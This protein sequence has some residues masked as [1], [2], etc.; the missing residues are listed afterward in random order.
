MASHPSIKRGGEQALCTAEQSSS[1]TPPKLS[2]TAGPAGLP[3]VAPHRQSLT[4]SADSRSACEGDIYVV[5]AAN[6][7]RFHLAV[8]LQG[9]FHPLTCVT[10]ASIQ[11]TVRH[12]LLPPSSTATAEPQ[13]KLLFE[14]M[15]LDESTT[16]TLPNNAVVIVH[17]EAPV[18]DSPHPHCCSHALSQPAGDG[19]TVVEMLS[20]SLLHSQAVPLQ[21]FCQPGVRSAMQANPLSTG[22]PQSCSRSS[23]EAKFTANGVRAAG[24]T[25]NSSAMPAPTQRLPLRCAYGSEGGGSTSSAVKPSSRTPSTPAP[26]SL[27]PLSKCA[28][29]N[30]G[31]PRTLTLATASN[32]PSPGPHDDVMPNATAPPSPTKHLFPSPRER[33][34]NRACAVSKPVLAA[35]AEPFDAFESIGISAAMASS[36]SSIESMPALQ[37]VNGMRSPVDGASSVEP[38][39]PIHKGSVAS[40][41]SPFRSSQR[42]TAA[43][44]AVAS[45]LHFS[46]TSSTV[47]SLRDRRRLPPAALL[48]SSSSSR[49]PTAFTS[50]AFSQVPPPSVLS[51]SVPDSLHLTSVS[52]AE[53]G[54]GNWTSALSTTP[55]RRTVPASTA[56]TGAVASSAL[57]H[58]PERTPDGLRKAVTTRGAT[59][60][61]GTR[62]TSTATGAAPG[63]SVKPAASLPAHE[64]PTTIR[65]PQLHCSVDV[66]QAAYDAQRD[67]IV[68]AAAAEQQRLLTRLQQHCD[69]LQKEK[70]ELLTKQLNGCRAQEVA[71]RLRALRAAQE[72]AAAREI[73]A[74]RARLGQC[75]DQI[76]DRWLS[77]LHTHSGQHDTMSQELLK[78]L[79][80]E[81]EQLSLNCLSL[82]ASYHSEKA[83]LQAL[84]QQRLLK[85]A[86]VARLKWESHVRRCTT[87]ELRGCLR[88]VARVRPPLRQAWLPD[89]MLTSTEAGRFDRGY[90]VQVPP[91]AVTFPTSNNTR[92]KNAAAAA[93]FP[94]VEVV[95]PSRNV[96]RRYAISAAYGSADG[97]DDNSQ[98]RLFTE[99]LQPLLEHMCRTGQHVAVLAFGTVGSGKTY[100]LIG[101]PVEPPPQWGH[102]R[103]SEDETSAKPRASS[104]HHYGDG[105]LTFSSEE[106]DEEGEARVGTDGL[107]QHRLG[108]GATLSS[109][110]AQPRGVTAVG[111]PP[112]RGITRCLDP[113][114]KEMEARVLQSMAQAEAGGRRQRSS[115]RHTREESRWRAQAGIDGRD[116]MLPR[117]VA[118]LTAHLR[119]NATARTEAVGEPIV[120]SVVFSMF[121]VYNDHIYDLLRAPPAEASPTKKEQ[122]GGEKQ[123]RRCRGSGPSPRPRWNAGSLPASRAKDSNPEGLTELQMELLPPTGWDSK[124]A[125]ATLSQQPQSTSQPQWRVKACEVEVRSAEEALEAIQLGMQR[126]R[127]AATLRNTQSS[128]SHLFLRFRVEVQRPAMPERAS[129]A[130][131]NASSAAIRSAL[132]VMQGGVLTGDAAAGVVSAGNADN[133]VAQ[134]ASTPKGYNFLCAALVPSSSSASSGADAA[135]PTN[136]AAAAAAPAPTC[137]TELLFTDFAGSERAD[138]VGAAGDSLKEAQYIS[139]SLSAVKDVLIALARAN[140]C[141]DAVAGCDGAFAAT[142]KVGENATGGPGAAAAASATVPL[143]ERWGAL[144]GRPGVTLSRS[145]PVFLQPRFSQLV[146][147]RFRVPSS[148]KDSSAEHGLPLRRRTLALVDAYVAGQSVAQWWRSWRASSTYIPFRACKTTQLLQSALGAPC[149]TLVLACVRPCTL[150]EVALPASMRHTKGKRVREL[151]LALFDRQA[152]LMMAEVHST[153]MFADRINAATHESDAAA[154]LPSSNTAAARV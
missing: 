80:T 65:S 44:H 109:G 124:D 147:D 51:R 28:R 97:S 153:L 76:L 94:C 17:R 71:S 3:T 91:A 23:R 85:E 2:S 128:R 118:W 37:S 126:R 83:R 39:L 143:A 50:P 54:D 103:Q 46:D 99:Q 87:E 110:N 66:R 48:L 9:P 114:D 69:A 89:W 115:E 131:A 93:P 60:D 100:T 90:A 154:T 32:I 13:L 125:A 47:D 140:P 79:E 120:E 22:V 111:V 152:P 25:R 81:G 137:V 98:Q 107:L 1:S 64:G 148:E 36:P 86:E 138:L 142:K 18:Q 149:K 14:G 92:D 88:V 58:T 73:D 52:D 49:Q 4:S 127:A 74:V 102:G 112:R 133:G 101:P 42:P 11:R 10:H 40:S 82:I 116:G 77:V 134:D 55:P 129:A 20:D 139:G 35:R 68:N 29:P 145:T 84:H 12:T 43:G 72:A 123:G 121:E 21:P 15:P 8:A 19:F 5:D 117:A 30:N 106:S 7:K 150:A 63:F 95:D 135:T 53:V 34:G 78:E 62:D 151:A 104:H 31:T 141:R 113:A 70:R 24:S 146:G 61:V 16:E 144:V 119:A 136:P 38:P 33:A 26:S 108:N 96:C 122:E 105:T 59:A 132:D 75:R 27:Q 57:F 41:L 56:P 130:A 67:A 6:S 45:P